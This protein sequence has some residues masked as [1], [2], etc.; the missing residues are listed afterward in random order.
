MISRMGASRFNGRHFGIVFLAASVLCLVASVCGAQAPASLTVKENFIKVPHTRQATD[1]T[2]GVAA[3][4]SVLGYYVEPIREDNLAKQIGAAY[5]GVKYTAIADFARS[6]GLHVEVRLNMTLADL[7]RAIDQK[8]PV[9]VAI[10]AWRDNPGDWAKE[11]DDGHYVVAI[12]YDRENIYFMDPSV[13]DNYAFIP[14]PEFLDRWH[15]MDLDNATKLIHLGM[16]MWK[17]KPVYDPNA[18]MRIE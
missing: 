4:Q 3:L 18:V 10:Q 14:V 5:E 16:I 1:H 11:W 6:K 7:Q 17:D 2:C 12:G 13:L 9:I 8:R 15:D